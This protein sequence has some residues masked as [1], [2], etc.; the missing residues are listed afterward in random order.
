[1][2]GSK[3]DYSK[4]VYRSGDKEYLDFNR[5]GTLTSF[6]LK[7]ANRNIGINVAKF[8]MKKFKKEIDRLKTRK[9]RKSN[10]K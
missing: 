1:M 5:F 2:Q 9:Q 7:L 8:N 3:I 10:T 6:C 4:L